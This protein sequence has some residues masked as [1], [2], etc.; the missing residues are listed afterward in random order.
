[1]NKNMLHTGAHYTLVH[2]TQ[3]YT[4]VHAT[5]LHATHWYTLHTGTH[6]MRYM[7]YTCT[8][9]STLH[10]G[11]HYT[12]VQDTHWCT[13]HT[14]ACHVVCMFVCFNN[15][16]C[17]TNTDLGYLQFVP[18]HLYSMKINHVFQFHLTQLCT[19]TKQYIGWQHNTVD[20]HRLTTQHCRLT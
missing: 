12:A 10:S 2:A 17:N 5:A 9:R 1:M 11:T 14:G 16:L 8:H 18:F 6:Y 19:A 20:L 3:R 7:L 13:L 4:P 15:W